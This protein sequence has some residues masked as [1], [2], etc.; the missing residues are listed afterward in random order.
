MLATI[1]DLVDISKIET[2]QMELYL[3][4]VDIKKEIE[5]QFDFFEE[6]TRNKELQFKLVNN[7]SEEERFMRTDRQKFS[8]IVMNLI[9]MQLNTPTEVVLKLAPKGKVRLYNAMLKILELAFSAERQKAIFRPI[10][11]SRHRRFQSF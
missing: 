10:C 6:E 7:L 4:S 2:G 11:T 1:N 9:K 5:E 8:S 3:Q